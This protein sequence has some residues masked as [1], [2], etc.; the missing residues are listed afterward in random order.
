MKKCDRRATKGWGGGGRLW[1][2]ES[3]LLGSDPSSVTL[4]E[5][6]SVSLICKMGPTVRAE[7]TSV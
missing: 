6:A 2:L 5:G 1:S 7:V 4:A 3:T